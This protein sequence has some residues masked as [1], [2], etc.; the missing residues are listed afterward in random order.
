M[1]TEA[2]VGVTQP[3]TSEHLQPPEVEETRKD[4]LPESSEGGLPY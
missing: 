3:Q 4:P 2:E 1:K